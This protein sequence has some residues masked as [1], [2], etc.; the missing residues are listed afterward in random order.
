MQVVFLFLLFAVATLAGTRGWDLSVFQGDVSESSFK[1][2]YNQGYRFGIIQSQ[3][4]NGL[5][6]PYAPNVYRRAHAAGFKFLDFYI[7][8]HKGTDGRVQARNQVKWLL[9]EGVLTKNML[10]ID[11][12][13][14][15]LFHPTH[16]QNIQMVKDMISE[17]DLHYKGCGRSSCVGIYA[18]KVQWDAI[19]GSSCTSFAKYDLWWPHYDNRPTFDGFNAFG[20]W[21]MP[22]IK[23]FT[24]T[25]NI[26]STQIDNNYY[27]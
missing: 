27:P 10:W 6:N 11:I 7:F 26:C 9:S 15:N 14:K 19:M 16:Q 3:R 25:T 23:Q 17:I 24:G 8:P 21:H 12:E 22:Q 13:A 20:G 4:S 1:C 5:K 18:S 2:L